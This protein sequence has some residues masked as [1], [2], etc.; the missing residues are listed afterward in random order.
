MLLV[1]YCLCLHYSKILQWCKV[2]F[3]ISSVLCGLFNSESWRKK[4]NCCCHIF[5]S[6]VRLKMALHICINTCLFKCD[7]HTCCPCLSCHLWGGSSGL[8]PWG[9]KHNIKHFSYFHIP[10][11]LRVFI[12]WTAL[13]TE[14]WDAH[15]FDWFLVVDRVNYADNIC[16][17]TQTLALTVDAYR[18]YTEWHEGKTEVT[19]TLDISW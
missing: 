17:S 7:Q 15:L 14:Q 1:I 2:T 3:Y 5:L 10:D 13:S 4:I 19:P 6:D 11:V 12:W 9:V 16:L 18:K 8:S